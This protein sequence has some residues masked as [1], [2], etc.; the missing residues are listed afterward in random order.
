MTA[1]VLVVGCG[2]LGLRTAHN[3]LT[4]GA[5]VWALRRH[6]PAQDQSQISWLQGD[7]SRPD[8]LRALPSDISHVVYCPAPDMRTQ[9]AY[10]SVFVDGLGHVLDALD[11]RHLQRLVFISSS[12]VYGDHGGA[13]IDEYTPVNPAGF[14]GTILLEA[15]SL[16]AQRHFSTV[17]LRLAG[18]YGP[19]CLQ[20]IDRLRAGQA[21]APYEPAHWANRIHID[22]AAAA[23]EH[24]LYLPHAQSVYIGSDDTPLPQHELYA[25]LARLIN[26]P[27]PAEGPAPA[28]IG[29]KKLS[30]AR[31]RDSGWRLRWPDA[32]E[33]YAALL[34]S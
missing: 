5:Q 24:L 12:A 22:D 13:W 23:V 3:L 15:E 30:N 33:G 10:R 25:Y 9:A 20:L 27:A 32:R 7:L 21:H 6:P 11:A 1:R 29:S 8:T 18:I 16:L 2:D 17:S 19:G 4:R 34:G 31:L 28:A 26:A 14:N